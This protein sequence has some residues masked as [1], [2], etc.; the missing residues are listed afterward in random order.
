[1]TDTSHARLDGLI[2][3]GCMVANGEMDGGGLVIEF[4]NM[5]AAAPAMLQALTYITG[6]FRRVRFQEIRGEAW[7]DGDLE[8]IHKLI[9]KASDNESEGS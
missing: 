5:H 9:D 7:H 3:C 8:A 1:M 6:L 4:C 2:D